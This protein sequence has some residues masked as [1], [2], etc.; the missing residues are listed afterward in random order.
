ME[1]YKPNN[2]NNTVGDFNMV[3]NIPK[4]RA[5]R[6]LTTQH[7]RIEHI[8]NIN[9][10]NNLIDIWQKQTAAPTPPPPTPLQKTKKKE[11]KEY[12]YFNDLADFKSR[13]DRFYL[14]ASIETNYKGHK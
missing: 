8:N 13:I 14:T 3:E 7:Y 11:K 9:N 1:K 12:T 10:T 4:D 6:N 2:T 5:G